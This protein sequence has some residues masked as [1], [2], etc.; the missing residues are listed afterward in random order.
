MVEKW[1]KKKKVREF[2]GERV[3]GE[4]NRSASRGYWVSRATREA[5]TFPALSFFFPLSRFARVGVALLTRVTRERER[6]RENLSGRPDK[7]VASW[8]CIRT[9]VLYLNF[10]EGSV[11]AR[12]TSCQLS[13][14]PFYTASYLA[15]PKEGYL[16]GEGIHRLNFSF[17]LIQ[18][19]LQD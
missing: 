11:F 8:P 13:R 16:L 10:R 17:I 4:D 6:E 3:P 15:Y 14:N 19:V 7:P 2:E 12:L 9:F 18:E 5:L 1:E